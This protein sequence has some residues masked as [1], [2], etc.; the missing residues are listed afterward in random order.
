MTLA[1]QY[2]RRFGDRK[3]G[4]LM[5]ELDTM[6]YITPLIYPNRCDNEA[7]IAERI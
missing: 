7:Y 5:R 6:H 4:R 3:Y 2:K 1:E